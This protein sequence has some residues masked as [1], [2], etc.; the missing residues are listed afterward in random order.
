[1]ANSCVRGALRRPSLHPPTLRVRVHCD[2]VGKDLDTLCESQ[3]A[4]ALLQMRTEFRDCEIVRE[5]GTL[6]S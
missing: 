5:D 2:E 1:M 6:A 3:S 4:L